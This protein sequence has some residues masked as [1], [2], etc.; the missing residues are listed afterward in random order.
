MMSKP[1]AK[2]LAII[3]GGGPPK[4]SESDDEKPVGDEAGEAAM[5]D[6][7]TAM[8]GNDKAA[9]LAAF[10]A[11]MD[12]CGYSHDDE[13]QGESGETNDEIEGG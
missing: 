4:D 1:K 12:A 7:F 13:G 2:G 5:G 9:G 10:R 3:I 6:L 8:K 11:L